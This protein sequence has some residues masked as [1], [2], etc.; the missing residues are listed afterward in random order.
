MGGSEILWT[1]WVGSG[2][3]CR[4]KVGT[5]AKEQNP[6]LLRVCM[7]ALSSALAYTVHHAPNHALK[8][9]PFLTRHNLISSAARA[10]RVCVKMI[11]HRFN[12]HETPT[13]SKPLGSV[14]YLTIYLSIPRWEGL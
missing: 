6:A 1:G 8:S 9:R 5:P 11:Y 4:C 10:R 3:W 13:R 12:T 2:R 14:P 7:A